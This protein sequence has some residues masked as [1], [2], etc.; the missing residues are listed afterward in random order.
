MLTAAGCGS[1]TVGPGVPGVGL[2]V[3]VQRGLPREPGRYAVAVGDDGRLTQQFTTEQVRN[4]IPV[5]LV[6]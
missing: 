4:N 5:R 3:P 6:L 1:I 2:R